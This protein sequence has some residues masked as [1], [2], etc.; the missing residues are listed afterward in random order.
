MRND[1]CASGF[2]YSR[3]SGLIPTTQP[4]VCEP[5]CIGAGNLF[6]TAR[7]NDDEDCC[8]GANG[9]ATCRSGFAGNFCDFD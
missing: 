5:E 9:D 1:E 7:C 3:V 2:C 8:S 4:P 6:E